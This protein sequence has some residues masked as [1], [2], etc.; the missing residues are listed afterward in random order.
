MSAW[1]KRLSLYSAALTC[2]IRARRRSVNVIGDPPQRL[3]HLQVSTVGVFWGRDFLPSFLFV[4]RAC[5]PRYI[6][7][8]LIIVPCRVSSLIICRATNSAIVIGL[9]LCLPSSE[10]GCDS[11]LLTKVLSTHHHLEHEEGELGLT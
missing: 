3:S 9:C 1:T 8:L 6:F 4:V 11:G 2:S 5:L 10:L 7:H